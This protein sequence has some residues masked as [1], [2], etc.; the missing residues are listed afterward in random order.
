MIAAES[1]ALLAGQPPRIP[2]HQRLTVSRAVD[3]FGQPIVDLREPMAGEIVV[4]GLAIP[5]LFAPGELEREVNLEQAL[6]GWGKTATTWAWRA[7]KR[8]RDL[9]PW[10]RCR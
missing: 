10:R 7:R 2:E 1:L 9:P 6:R 5:I 8:R 3:F 4:D